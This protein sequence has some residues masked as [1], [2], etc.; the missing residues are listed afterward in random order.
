MRPFQRNLEQYNALF[1]KTWMRVPLYATAFGCFFIGGMQLPAR[2]FPK[3]TPKKF[4]GINHSYYTGSQD[5]VSKF[6]MFENFEHESSKAD[7]ANYLSVYGT[8]PL[9]KTEMMDNIALHALK[10]FD[11]GKM[12]QVK[13]AGKD[14]DD[15]FWSFGK[16]HGLENIAFADPNEVLASAGNPVKI[17]KI[18]NRVNGYPQKVDSFE[19]LVSEVQGALKEFHEKIDKMSMG[20]SDRKK[21]LALPFY[22]AK[23]SQMPEPRRGQSEFNLF[24]KLSGGRTWYDDAQTLVDEEYKITEF[25]YENYIDTSLISRQAAETSEFKRLV[26]VLNLFSKTQHE[27]LQN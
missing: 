23:R 16:I 17:Q 13:R 3:L 4:E 27:Q 6:R 7:I 9:T 14:K 24:E 11:L 18:V 2:V 25:D 1:R 20:S 8:Q 5:V 19:H 12:F 10:E 21:I 15:L 26:R 22:L